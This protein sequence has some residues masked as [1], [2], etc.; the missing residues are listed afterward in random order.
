MEWRECVLK[1]PW[2]CI[3]VRVGKWGLQHCWA[4]HRHRADTQLRTGI[5]INVLYFQASSWMRKMSLWT[6]VLSQR[7]TKRVCLGYLW[8]GG[9]VFF[10]FKLFDVLGEKQNF[11]D[12]FILILWLIIV[13]LSIDSVWK[14]ALYFSQCWGLLWVLTGPCVFS[15]H[16]GPLATKLSSTLPS[17][18]PLSIPSCLRT[19]VIL[20]MLA[21]RFLSTFFLFYIYSSCFHSDLCR[22]TSPRE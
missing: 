1:S 7:K 11:L 14:T 4:W 18:G 9:T 12:S 6:A 19:V 20:I 3:V 8:L 15:F 10:I 21:D 5:W 22:P 17:P 13:Y 2:N 16:D